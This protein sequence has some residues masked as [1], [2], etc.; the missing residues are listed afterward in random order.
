MLAMHSMSAPISL[1]AMASLQCAPARLVPYHR[2]RRGPQSS[3]PK[4]VKGS[5]SQRALVDLAARLHEPIF[6]GERLAG[7]PRL[8][9]FGLVG[10]GVGAVGRGGDSADAV[11]RIG[12]DDEL[13]GAAERF[14]ERFG[15]LQRAKLVGLATGDQERHLYLF[16]IAVPVEG[17]AKFVE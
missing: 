6:V 8:Q 1:R 11:T 14:H 15:I 10:A 9:P 5:S 13:L 2:P 3:S 17:L 12:V 7:Q 16:G 4:R